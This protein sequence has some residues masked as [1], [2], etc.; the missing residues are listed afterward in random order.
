LSDALYTRKRRRQA[1][2]ARLGSDGFDSDH[3]QQDPTNV[4]GGLS[5]AELD[6]LMTTGNDPE[7]REHS[8]MSA[9]LRRKKRHRASALDV[10]LQNIL[11]KQQD[12]ESHDKIHA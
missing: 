11:P 2:V 6:G 7:E 8:P 4:R 10:T 9:A 1:G 5:Q 12:I 3:E